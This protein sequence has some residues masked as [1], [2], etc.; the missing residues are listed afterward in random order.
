MV[1]GNE[2]VIADVRKV[3]RDAEYV[4]K[5]PEQLCHELLTTCYMSTDNSSGESAEFVS[6][7]H[8]EN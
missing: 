2:Q 4:V 6:R 7:T 1:K 8:E 3:V 5:S